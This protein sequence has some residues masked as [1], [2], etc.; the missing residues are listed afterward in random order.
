MLQ[1]WVKKVD[2][3][4]ANAVVFSESV[5]FLS[6]LMVPSVMLNSTSYCLFSWV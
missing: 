6:F 2:K 5:G 4:S 3:G 1:V